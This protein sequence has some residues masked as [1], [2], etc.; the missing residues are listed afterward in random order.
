M[1]YL[2]HLGLM[3]RDSHIEL[4]ILQK[5]LRRSLKKYYVGHKS[6]N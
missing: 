1:K 6:A 2:N 3:T 5:V 4:F